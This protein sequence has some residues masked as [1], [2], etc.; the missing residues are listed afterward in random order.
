MGGKTYKE[1]FHSFVVLGKNMTE[2]GAAVL[3]RD[4]VRS[5]NRIIN[6]V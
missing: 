2:R 5:A 1:V 4:L 6:E 3:D